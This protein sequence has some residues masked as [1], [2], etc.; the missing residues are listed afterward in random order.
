MLSVG[1]ASVRESIVDWVMHEPIGSFDLW[2]V[3]RQARCISVG[4]V[5]SDVTIKEN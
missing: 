4:I 1:G 5:H 2:L 3:N